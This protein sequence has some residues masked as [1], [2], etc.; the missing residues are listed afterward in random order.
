MS[1]STLEARLALASGVCVAI[2]AGLFAA[3]S[4]AGAAPLLAILLGLAAGLLASVVSAALLWRPFAAALR[5]IADGVR[6]FQ[7]SDFG[8]RLAATGDRE[9]D[10]LVTLYNRM[11]DVLRAERNELYQRELLL[12]TLL[13]G[14]PM[15]IL[16]FNPL[17]RVSY[18]NAAA[19]RLFVHGGRLEGLLRTDLDAPAPALRAAL[20][21]GADTTATSPVRRERRREVA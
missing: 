13:Q 15:A 3:L 12:D 1:R 16:L 4:A 18:A 2:A 10:E 20:L 6:G 21:A 7:E 19:R 17:G 9:I 11:G 5:G 8:F 14:A